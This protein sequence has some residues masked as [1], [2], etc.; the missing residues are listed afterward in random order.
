M[1][2]RPYTG[3]AATEQR[4]PCRRRASPRAQRLGSPRGTWTVTRHEYVAE[5][6]TV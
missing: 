3:S 5:F 4:P 2:A 6:Q 1:P